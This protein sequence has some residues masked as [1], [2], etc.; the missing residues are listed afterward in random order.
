MYIYQQLTELGC[1]II[2]VNNFWHNF[3]LIWNLY[4]QKL[5]FIPYN[6]KRKKT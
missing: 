5:Y 4:T 3:K 1:T 2:Y 6:L